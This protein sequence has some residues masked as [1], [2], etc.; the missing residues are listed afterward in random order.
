MVSNVEQVSVVCSDTEKNGEVQSRGFY[1][2]SDG[3]TH[4]MRN[5]VLNTSSDTQYSMHAKNQDTVIKLEGATISGAGF[6]NGENNFDITKS[7]LVSAVLAEDG[8]KVILD[9]KSNI[10]SSVIGVEAQRGGEVKVIEGTVSAHYVGA[11]AGSGASVNLSNTKISVVGDLA[12]AGLVS[13]GGKITMDSGTIILESGVAVRSETGGHIKLDGV[14]ITAKKT[15]G[16]SDSTDKFGRA[17]ILVSDNAS[18]EFTNGDVTT[19]ANALWVKST[20][21][22]VEASSSR[23]KRSSDI[24][25]AVNRA[26][27]ESS[28]VKVEGDKSYGIYF[29]GKGQQEID[30]RNRNKVLGKII[31]ESSG[32]GYSA[33]EVSVVKRS[34]EPL[35]ERTP[36][37]ITGEVSLKKT[38]FE[39]TKSVA[40]YGNNSSGHLSLENKTELSGDVL[41]KAEDGSNILVSVDDSIIAG[42]A[43]VDSRSY[44][45][46][47]L[48]N[49]STWL[50]KKA[51]YKRWSP[52]DLECV[53][54]C[55]SSVS[56]TDSRIE[57]EPL[58]SEDQYKLPLPG[59]YQTLRIGRG[60]G[61]VYRAH[62]NASI[63]LNARLNPDDSND[64]QLS[65]RLVIHGDIEG[66]TTVH[67]LGT[68]GNKEEVRDIAEVS[69]SISIIQVYGQAEHDSFQLD[70]DYVALQNSPYKYTLRS[71]SPEMTLKQEYSYQK[72]LKD[73]GT[74]WDFRLENQYVK[75][76]ISEVRSIHL[77][78]SVR[79]VVPQVPTYL[80]L[81]NSIFHAGLMDI[82][83]QNKQ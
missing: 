60:E 5:P 73:G 74:F 22:G 54:S 75:S 29:D 64:K 47:D 23:R 2:C 35:Y 19:D 20:A 46:L 42:E 14:A 58:D 4:V 57:F 37:K 12:A 34:A 16:R 72:F 78:N 39:V 9:K 7:K 48:V 79:S 28:T 18:V 65:D 69:Q 49:G 38:I 63:N 11:L 32:K 50:L 83:S 44:A 52:P 56:L 41:L 81:P 36:I 61:T 51:A 31:A 59:Q 53:G 8:A 26:N 68:S 55:I 17:A 67:I 3:R 24:L 71:Y 76:A 13:Q 15:A 66:K 33:E 27:I 80:L 1:S 45:K 6:S 21:S 40:V 62:G 30:Q 77:G 25:P 43:Y 82:S 70:G 10:I